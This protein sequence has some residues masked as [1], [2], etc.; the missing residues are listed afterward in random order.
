MDMILMPSAASGGKSP[1]GRLPIQRRLFLAF[2]NVT[3]ADKHH[4]IVPDRLAQTRL[5]QRVGGVAQQQ[6]TH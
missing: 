1:L 6:Q 5:F 3:A 4:G 2:G